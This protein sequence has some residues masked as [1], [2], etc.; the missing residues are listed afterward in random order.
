MFFTNP[1]S[2]FTLSCFHFQMGFIFRK[3]HSSQQCSGPYCAAVCEARCQKDELLVSA[4]HKVR[5]NQPF[6]FSLST[7]AC[8][9][10]QCRQGPETGHRSENSG[11][12]DQLLGRR[13][14]AT[15]SGSSA[16]G[17]TVARSP[18]DVPAG[19][20]WDRFSTV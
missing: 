14:V 20:I 13:P 7:C 16:R 2:R 3:H 4:W 9:L 19:Q 5:F 15:S 11:C 18:A 8:Q 6:C 1:I 12:C 10:S 17:R